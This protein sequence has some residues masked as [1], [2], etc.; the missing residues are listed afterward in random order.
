MH[1][2]QT[3]NNETQD[4][5]TIGSLSAMCFSVPLDIPAIDITHRRGA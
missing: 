4:L 5:T 2:Q 3:D 1:T